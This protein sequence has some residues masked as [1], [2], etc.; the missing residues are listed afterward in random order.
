MQKSSLFM[1]NV[2]W[3]LSSK[4]KLMIP[5][6]RGK[7]NDKLHLQRSM[8]AAA[9]RSRLLLFLLFFSLA[10]IFWE[11]KKYAGI[12]FF[13]HCCLKSGRSE[14]ATRVYKPCES[15]PNCTPLTILTFNKKKHCKH[16]LGLCLS[17]C[18]S[19]SLFLGFEVI[20]ISTVFKL[21]CI[22]LL[23]SR[24]SSWLVI[25]GCFKRGDVNPWEWEILKVKIMIISITRC[26][27]PPDTRRYHY[28]SIQSTHPLI[29]L[30]IIIMSSSYQI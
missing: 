20:V 17:I 18:C 10:D 22:F 29:L 6:L 24:S 21:L 13:T 30:F 4:D 5:T 1:N 19:M 11:S 28:P 2:H 8:L 23:I 27:K 3:T 9:G 12:C 26:S 14:I 7:S 16:K 15:R 25:C